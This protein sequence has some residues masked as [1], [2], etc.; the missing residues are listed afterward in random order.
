MV[1]Q[2]SHS[3]S[4]RLTAIESMVSRDAWH[5]VRAALEADPAVTA[6]NPEFIAWYGESLLRCGA[7]RDAVRWFDAH[8]ATATG[9]ANVRAWM[10]AVNL[11]GA[12]AFETG[13]VSQAEDYFALAAELGGSRGDPLVAARALNNLA[14]VASSRGEWE[15]A[16]AY[17]GLALAA[18]Q[19]AGSTRGLAEAYHNM[20]T[21]LIE[22]GQLERASEAG[23]QALEYGQ[24][25]EEPRLHAYLKANR[26]EVLV[27]LGDA[28]L[29]ARVAERAAREFRAIDDQAGEAHALRIV[30][31]SKLSEG[32]LAEADALLER[33]T[34]LAQASGVLRIEAECRS[35]WAQCGIASGDSARAR[36]HLLAA[37]V[38]YRR[39]GAGQKLQAVMASI[40]LVDALDEEPGAR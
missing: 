32:A 26:A 39:L 17:Y 30:G 20:A 16:H 25:V 19:R 34:S 5:E 1:M 15:T 7:P 8:L 33:A 2:T 29:A 14:L 38:A 11:A 4:V 35:A 40:A 31:L 27:R 24:R 21:T 6:S 36:K 28:V 13:N 37:A 12:A 9:T 18:Y 3:I 10:R 23:R 22:A